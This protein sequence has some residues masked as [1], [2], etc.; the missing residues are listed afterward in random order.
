MDYL[1]LDYVVVLGDEIFI[2]QMNENPSF[3]DVQKLHKRD[4]VDGSELRL[5]TWDG[6]KTW[7]FTAAGSLFEMFGRCFLIFDAKCSESYQVLQIKELSPAGASQLAVDL[8]YLRKAGMLGIPPTW[9]VR[10]G[11]GNPPQNVVKFRFGKPGCLGSI[12]DEKLPSYVGIVTN[13]DKDPY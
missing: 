3:S 7:I 4:T 8:E 1:L 10:F 6:A 2:G 13:H 9:G 12:G 11:S 5:T